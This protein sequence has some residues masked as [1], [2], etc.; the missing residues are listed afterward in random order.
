MLLQ[1]NQIP[2]RL[3]QIKVDTKIVNAVKHE[4]TKLKYNIK[5]KQTNK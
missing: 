5:N 3:N 2:T 1:L 4:Q